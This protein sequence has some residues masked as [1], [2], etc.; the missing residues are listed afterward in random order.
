[1]KI[2]VTSDWH[3]SLPP[4]QDRERIAQCDLLLLAGD[5]FSH[6]TQYQMGVVDPIA[7]YLIELR[8]KGIP[9]ALTPG[10]HDF[11]LYYG[12]LEKHPD[13]ADWVGSRTV[14]RLSVNNIEVL[15]ADFIEEFLGAKV[16]VDETFEF[17]GLKIYGTPWTPE[18]Y[19]WAF[20]LEEDDLPEMYQKMPA[21]A[22]IVISHG[23]PRF[24][25]IDCVLQGEPPYRKCGSVSLTNEILRKVP[26]HLFCGHIHSGFHGVT[27]IGNTKCVNVSLLDEGYHVAYPPFYLNL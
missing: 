27:E 5:I 16:L 19:R 6:R 25:Q 18:F 4:R 20:M 11:G 15:D 23:P 3:G 17:N 9:V 10:N 14:P 12:Y 21:D 2:A 8:D 7:K 13:I 24:N 1:M 26:K 22:D